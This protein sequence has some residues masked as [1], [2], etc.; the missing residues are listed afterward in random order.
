MDLELADPARFF[1]DKKLRG[2]VDSLLFLGDDYRS[3]LSREQPLPA[4]NGLRVALVSRLF[5]NLSCFSIYHLN[6]SGSSPLFEKMAISPD[7]DAHLPHHCLAS[8][9]KGVEA[10]VASN[11]RLAFSDGRTF[12]QASLSQFYHGLFLISTPDSTFITDNSRVFLPVRSFNP[13]CL[14]TSD[15]RSV[16]SCLVENC[17]YV[18]I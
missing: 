2:A 11:S 6:G 17:D 12:A 3:W 10:L 18:I 13:E 5:N 4:T 8:G 1:R 15:G 14:V 7:S 16:I 9:G